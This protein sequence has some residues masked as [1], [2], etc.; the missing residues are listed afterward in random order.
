MGAVKVKE[1]G[2]A[3]A[4]S[5]VAIGPVVG[6]AIE[7]QATGETPALAWRDH[8][9]PLHAAALDDAEAKIHA[10]E[11]Q[12]EAWATSDLGRARAYREAQFKLRPRDLSGYDR[13]RETVAQMCDNI[14]AHVETPRMAHGA[15]FAIAVDEHGRPRWGEF[16]SRPNRLSRRHRLGASAPSDI[17]RADVERLYDL[18]RRF[19]HAPTVELMWIAV[20]EIAQWCGTVLAIERQAR[21]R[22]GHAPETAR[23]FLLRYLAEGP[24]PARAVEAAAAAIGVTEKQ[25]RS[26]RTALGREG[27]MSWSWHGRTSMWQLT[28]TCPD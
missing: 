19:E 27:A 25:L 6:E 2:R 12:V 16:T 23:T 5:R 11:V 21:E 28:A 1:D 10:V 8:I 9:S 20:E 18:W 17:L 15:R 3:V 14:A 24:R 13:L 7:A 4:A 26:A 22:A